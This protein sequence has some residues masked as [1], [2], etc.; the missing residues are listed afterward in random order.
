[1][2]VIE[3]ITRDGDTQIF[4]IIT[5]KKELREWLKMIL[6]DSLYSQYKTGVWEDEDS[7]LSFYDKTGKYH[8]YYAGDSVKRFNVSNIKKLVNNNSG[9]TVIYGKV[10]IVYNEHYGDWEIVFD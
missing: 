3:K 7:S 8:G 2:K 6:C 4:E 10:P 1:M 9:S 5:S